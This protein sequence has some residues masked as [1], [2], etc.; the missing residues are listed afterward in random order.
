MEEFF[1]KKFNQLS[2][3]H[4]DSKPVWGKMSAQHMI[5][6]LLFSLRISNGKLSVGCFV[7]EERW[8]TMKKV[9]MSDRSLPK[10]F[11][12]PI[13]GENLLPLEFENL[14]HAKE[15]LIK[16]FSDFAG[17]FKENPAATF[18]NPTFGELNGIEWMQ[19]HKKHFQHHFEQFGLL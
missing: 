10:N 12:N 5:E 9:L 16:E 13:I 3:L 14:H 4:T 8:S 18:L 1:E 6:H 15:N 7:P 11:I 2:N 19:F 17:Y